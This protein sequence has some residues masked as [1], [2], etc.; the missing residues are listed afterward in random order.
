MVLHGSNRAGLV[1]GLLRLL[2]GSLLLLGLVACNSTPPESIQV[3]VQ[4]QAVTVG[5]G[6]VVAFTATVRGNQSVAWSAADGTIQGSG[7][8]VVYTA[9]QTPGAYQVVVHSTVDEAARATAVVTVREA[10]LQDPDDP[11]DPEDPA[12]DAVLQVAGLR[13][14]PAVVP[15]GGGTTVA[16]DV[17]NFGGVASSA[18]TARILLSDEADTPDAALY[19]LAE[20]AVPAI[21]AGEL[22]SLSESVEIP[23]GLGEG[24]YFVWVVVDD[25]IT[26]AGGPATRT[27]LVVGAPSDA[28]TQ[29]DESVSI[30]DSA[31]RSAVRLQLGLASSSISCADMQGLTSLTASGLGI[32][33]L[34]GLQH[35]V[36]LSFLDAYANRISDLTPLAG[37]T[38]LEVLNLWINEVNDASPLAGLTNLTF[39][40]LADNLINDISAL[41]NL[42]QLVVLGLFNNDP[43]PYA[44]ISDISALANMTQ[45][46]DLSLSGNVISDISPLSNKPALLV[47][48]LGNN[49][50]SDLSPLAGSTE[51]VFLYLYENPIG[52][53]GPLSDLTSLVELWIDSSVGSITSIEALSGMRQLES[54][55][56]AGHNIA[57]LQP[58]AELTR[59]TRLSLASNPVSDISPLAG[60]TALRVL[61]LDRTQAGGTLVEDVSPLRNL[62]ALESLSIGSE[63]LVDIG[64]LSNLIN[65]QELWISSSGVAD[66]SPLAGLTGLERMSFWGSEVV[67]VSPLSN[68]TNLRMIELTH[69]NIHDVSP[70]A[71]LRNLYSLNLG[72]N[73][74]ADITPLAALENMQGLW[75]YENDISDI[76]PLAGLSELTELSLFSNQ[77]SDL[78][79]LAGLA[80]LW[81]LWAY[82][83]QLTD[84]GP[85]VANSGV[86]ADD[87]IDVSLNCLDLS[88]SSTASGQIAALRARGASVT[89]QPQHACGGSGAAAFGSWSV[90]PPGALRDSRELQ[91]FEPPPPADLMLRHGRLGH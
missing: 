28:C 82:D 53:I 60:L 72:G 57:N 15:A 42:E 9:P 1:P 66:L 4:P 62:T 49:R 67:D 19:V 89:Y 51:L 83:N 76:S 56:L 86:G 11:E 3:S 81:Q 71:N 20:L 91:A 87:F 85:L 30:P 70:L 54:L 69:A 18:A 41:R 80:Q 12:E 37:L 73:A 50:L 2:A 25:P 44:Q 27:S 6:D 45:L 59:L 40:S 74:I 23:L 22:S 8:S 16:F 21:G 52:N 26:L 38:S 34:E 17:H 88:A 75:I 84:L 79:A 61:M 39:L 36:N 35:A 90:D 33:S 77:L 47:L 10:D 55:N 7:L 32:A 48:S 68:L 13:L 78:G 14:L 29:P 43:Q 65:L 31:L 58:L 64:P 24:V 5:P 46:E 63:R